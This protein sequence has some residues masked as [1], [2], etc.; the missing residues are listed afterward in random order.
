MGRGTTTLE[1]TTIHNKSQGDL[2]AYVRKRQAI[3]L[4]G[5]GESR[6]LVYRIQIF[7]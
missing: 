1:I 3:Y 4:G 5:V 6:H 7:R 2:A